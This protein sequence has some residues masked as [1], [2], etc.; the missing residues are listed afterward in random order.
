MTAD[1]RCSTVIQ[2]DSQLI[3]F[4][5]N[6]HFNG[7]VKKMDQHFLDDVWDVLLREAFHVIF[8]FHIF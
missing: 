3:D 8:L 6:Q 5:A 7:E 1:D 2:K 4:V